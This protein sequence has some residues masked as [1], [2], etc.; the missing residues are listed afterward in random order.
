MCKCTCFSFYDKWEK[1]RV[2]SNGISAIKT[3]I[4]FSFSDVNGVGGVNASRKLQPKLF[5]HIISGNQKSFSFLF[6]LLL[7]KGEIYFF[8]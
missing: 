4:C 8:L 6:F 5:W 3:I 2:E 7:F 1:I